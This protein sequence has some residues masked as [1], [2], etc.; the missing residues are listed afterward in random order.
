MNAKLD[1]G[2]EQS[3][4]PL[5]DDANVNYNCFNHKNS[6]KELLSTFKGRKY[7]RK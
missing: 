1:N 2:Y 6:W 5:K 7:N 4:E 3:L